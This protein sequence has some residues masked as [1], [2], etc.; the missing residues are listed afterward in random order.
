MGDKRVIIRNDGEPAIVALAEQVK[1]MWSG[2]VVLENRPA[3]E[4]QSNGQAEKAV[5]TLAR[6]VR[7]MKLAYDAAVKLKLPAA[8]AGL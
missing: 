2:E 1:D 8:S 7:T 3:G 6:Q 4:S 5:Q